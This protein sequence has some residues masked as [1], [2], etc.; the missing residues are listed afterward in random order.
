MHGLSVDQVARILSGIL[1]GII[2]L[3]SSSCRP[4]SENGAGGAGITSTPEILVTPLSGE[5]VIK[6]D[7]ANLRAGPGVSFESLG[8]LN[9][10]E[11][12]EFDGVTATG[13]WYRLT[14]GS[15]IA[16]NFVEMASDEISETATSTSVAAS[17]TTLP[18]DTP[19]PTL[20][21]SATASQVPLSPDT[22]TPTPT[23][24]PPMS[25]PSATITP[26]DSIVTCRTT[27]DVFLLSG[28]GNAN[29]YHIVGSLTTGRGVQVLGGNRQNGNHTH[30]KVRADN[31]DQ[32]WLLSD[33]CP[34]AG[35]P[36]IGFEAFPP[37]FTPTATP[38]PTPSATPTL[39]PPDTPTPTATSAAPAT[40]AP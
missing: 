18:A 36:S 35:D 38:T 31:G 25:T 20:A 34:V 3:T 5:L 1:Y 6:V 26:T 14:D 33:L 40:P 7:I 23:L 11:T 27:G 16:A 28:P 2:L 12:V 24:L 17:P 39:I 22:P 13:S 15:W 9:K 37:T 30:Y 10:D 32:G 21:L 19:S 8:T 29:A 4:V